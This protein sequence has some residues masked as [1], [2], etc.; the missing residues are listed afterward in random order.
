MNEKLEF[1]Q[2]PKLEKI[3]KE[4]ISLEMPKQ[5]ESEIIIQRHEKYRSEEDDEKVGS[6][7]EDAA[8]NAYQQTREIFE[9]KLKDLT[10]QERQNVRVLILGSTTKHFGKGQ[11]SME[12]ADMVAQAISDV[13]QENSMSEEQ[14]LNNTDAIM[15]DKV[16]P[17]DQM[18]APRMFDDSPEF[19]EYLREKYK[20][21]GQ[22][23]W[24]AFEE[25]WEK[26]KREELGAESSM[27]IVERF[28]KYIEVLDRFARRF[29]KKNPD[30]S[31]LIWTVSHY[32]T[33]SPYVKN[34][35]NKSD[36]N[37]F[38]PVDYGA[39]ISIKIDKEQHKTSVV[40]G[41]QYEIN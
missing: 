36:P 17:V 7:Y 24:Q 34:K 8:D 15:G 35:I 29:H 4:D 12:T 39:G 30:H 6:L 19:V 14:I 37:Q 18:Q 2:E 26:E 16:R 27:D 38:V 23:F 41:Q 31:L 13:M 3:T 10:E 22:Q 33:I 5:G 9:A 25:D 21:Q 40:N 11:R 32:D 28:S 20:G 1:E